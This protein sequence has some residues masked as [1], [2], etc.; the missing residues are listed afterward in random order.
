M[1]EVP[2]TVLSQVIPAKKGHMHQDSEVKF[3]ENFSDSGLEK[4]KVSELHSD[5]QLFL[6]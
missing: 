6:L 5:G 1:F 3:F 4:W 2:F